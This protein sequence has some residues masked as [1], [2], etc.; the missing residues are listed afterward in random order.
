MARTTGRFSI[1][2]DFFKQSMYMKVVSN[3]YAGLFTVWNLEKCR[4]K[5]NL[6][7]GY[8]LTTFSPNY[9]SYD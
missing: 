6:V 8:L 7:K 2:T 3:Y 1:V 5:I 9:A 4:L